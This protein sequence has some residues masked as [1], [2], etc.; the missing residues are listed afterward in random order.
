MLVTQTPGAK[1]LSEFRVPCEGLWGPVGPW[2]HRCIH[3]PPHRSDH[4]LSL[5]VTS[6]L[7]PGGSF[8]HSQLVLVVLPGPLPYSYWPKRVHETQGLAYPTALSLMPWALASLLCSVPP[9]PVTEE[10][11]GRHDPL[12]T[13]T[14]LQLAQRT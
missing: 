13:L 12:A 4:S 3:F 8:P 7:I 11:P 5:S 6:S 1:G 14:W 10:A 9:G 2:C